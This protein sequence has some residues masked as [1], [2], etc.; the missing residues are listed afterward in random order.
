MIENLKILVGAAKKRKE[1]LDHILF[2]GPPGLGK[3]TLS[4]VMGKEM[5]VNV[6][7]TA[8]P[9]IE[10]AGDL[11]PALERARRAVV[12]D[13]LREEA[14]CA[15]MRLFGALGRHAEA[16]RQYRELERVL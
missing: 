13:P 15:V 3:T 16:V 14:H 11:E 12:A 5:G 8:G 10:R 6:R 2:Y 4:H 7:P 1:P 9:S